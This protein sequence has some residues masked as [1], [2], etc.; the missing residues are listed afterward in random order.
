MINK[1]VRIIE[2]R[3]GSVIYEVT[4]TTEQKITLADSIVD[5]REKYADASGNMNIQLASIESAN[6]EISLVDANQ[7]LDVETKKRVSDKLL[8]M[9]HSIKLSADNLAQDVKVYAAV[10]DAFNKKYQK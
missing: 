10:V 6:S 2:V 3:E 1:E 9:R 7:E 5:L 8:N 4:V